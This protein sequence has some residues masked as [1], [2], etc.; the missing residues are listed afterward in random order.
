MFK[1]LEVG[2]FL[3]LCSSC[4]NG[5]IDKYSAGSVLSW[6]K[7]MLDFGS[8]TFLLLQDQALWLFYSSL[9]R[10]KLEDVELLPFW[11]LLTLDWNSRQC[12]VVSFKQRSSY[13]T[14][15]IL[16][17]FATDFYIRILRK[18][19]GTVNWSVSIVGRWNQAHF[20]LILSASHQNWLKVLWLLYTLWIFVIR[21]NF[22]IEDISVF[23]YDEFNVHISH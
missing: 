9:E 13:I 10:N 19:A 18:G 3:W 6:G 15:L 8:I 11:N 22:G 1:G 7:I 14:I 23:R 4:G 5:Q 2:L 21:S 20:S 12:F 16:T 17:K